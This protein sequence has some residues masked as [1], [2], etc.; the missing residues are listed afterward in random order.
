MRILV[1]DVGGTKTLLALYEGPD[2]RS[3][4]EVRRARFQNAAHSGLAPVLR[5]FVDPSESVDATVIGVAGPIDGDACTATNLPWTIDAREL[6]QRLSV[7]TTALLNDFEAIA[8][9]LGELPDEALVVLQDREIDPGAPQAVI[10]AGTG[11]GEAIVV[12]RDHGLP[13]VLPTEGGHVDFAPRDDAEIDLLRHA[14]ERFGRVS[15]ERLVSGPGLGTIYEH[16]V[17]SGE[18]PPSAAVRARIDA[19][20]DA[21]AV[22]GELGATGA[23]ASASAAVKRF[24][25][26]YGVEAGNLALKSLPFGGFY[27]AGGIAPKLIDVVRDGTFLA[28]FCGKGRMEPLMD[29]IHVSVVMDPAV[30]LLG[31]RRKAVDL[32]EGTPG[33]G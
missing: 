13:R 31:A 15:V 20:E 28:A 33:H 8:L 23:D 6:S 19:G 2:A 5:A 4:R 24:V 7:P 9:G 26:L 17:A 18:A 1:G 3:L 32:L 30:G 21:G 22:I 14:R 10:G 16:I 11:L 25:S 12:P 27:V 29:R